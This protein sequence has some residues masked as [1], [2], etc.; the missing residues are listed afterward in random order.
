MNV[1]LTQLDGKL[2]NLALMKLSSWHK[3]QGNGVHLT[4]HVEPSL[5]EPEYDKVYG[6][7]IFTFS[8][9]HQDTFARNFP[10]AVMAGTG[11]INP[12]TVEQVIG[13]EWEKYDYTVYP[14]YRF[15]LGFTQ[16]GCRLKCGF[17]VVP[18]K[19]GRPRS[20]NTIN[21][22][23]RGGATP[24]AVVLL[25]NDFFGQ[26]KEEWRARLDEIIDGGFKVSLN[27]GIN[28][29]LIDDEAAHWLA[30]IP[31][32]DDQFTV[33]RLYTAWDNLR[34][35]EIFFRGV[36]MLRKAGIPP[37]H[38]MVY[39]LIGYD[40][41]ETWERIF[42]RYNK[43]AEIG[44]LVYPMVYNNNRPYLKRFQRWVIRRYCKFIPWDKF[45]NEGRRA[46]VPA[47]RSGEKK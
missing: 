46:S 10:D 4:R 22:I 7:A 24:K 34:D 45:S 17:C 9:P 16:R 28:V 39:M 25:D 44:I 38:L 8:K 29:R 5:F 6:S 42:Y 33:R 32:Y 40:P 31:Y 26:Q 13:Q 15:S 23:W 36:D 37:R 47:P 14:D 18:K 1:R 11:T 19:E 27:Q 2:P 35:E 30:K 3:A 43:M 20:V 41:E 21:D 12:Q